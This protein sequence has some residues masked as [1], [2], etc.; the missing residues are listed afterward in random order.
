MTE[1]LPVNFWIIYLIGINLSASGA[2]FIDKLHAKTS[3]RRSPERTLL[4][5]GALGGALG[6]WIV[7]LIIR[8]KTR[9]RKFML[10]LP[11]FVILHIVLLRIFFC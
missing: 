8:H 7:M 9:R 3:A 1:L 4:L 2:A 5:L 11:L 10:G 6:E